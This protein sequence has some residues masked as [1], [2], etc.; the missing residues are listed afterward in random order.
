MD[1]ERWDGASSA[2]SAAS[3]AVAPPYP[4][5][6]AAL[7]H[8][9]PGG[10]IWV[11]RFNNGLTSAGAALTGPLAA[12][13]RAEEGE[14]AWARLLDGLPTVADQF[15]RAT[16]MRPFVHVPYLAFRSGTIAGKNW[17]LLPSAAGIIDPLLSTGFPLTL[18]GIGRLLDVLEGTTDGSERAAALATYAR[19]TADEL[20]VTEMLVAALYANM[21]APATFKRL[22]LMYF[23]AASYSEA[24]RRLGRAHLAPGFLLHAHPRFG[25]QLRS[26]ATLALGAP[27]GA[28]RDAL[29]AG[30]DAAIEPFDTAGLLDRARADWYPVRA[31]D[32]RANAHKLDATVDEVQRMLESCGFASGVPG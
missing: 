1:V 19:T 24:A 31:D 28:A 16:A 17:A 26:C 18:L 6:D 10:W 3:A 11:L 23:A 29:L 22:G 8:V 32:L 5:D 15:R 14:P 13:L 20:D 7:H 2:S 4:P 25:P 27:L 30:I 12:R 21:D 9:F